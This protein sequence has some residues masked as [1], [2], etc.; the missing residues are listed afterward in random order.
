MNKSRREH[1]V[2]LL[3]AGLLLG[4]V[5]TVGIRYWN[6]P[7]RRTD[8][9]RVTAVFSSYKEIYK[10]GNIQKIVVYFED[11]EQLSIDGICVRHE[12]EKAISQIPPG[13]VVKMMVHPNSDVIL[14]MEYGTNM[15]LDFDESIQRL[16]YEIT[17]FTCLGVFCYIMAA[18][19][20]GDLVF[21]KIHKIRR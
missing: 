20:G 1:A 18:V 11:H 19:G 14:E 3:I 6:A 5:F 21:Q 15:L 2:F 12:Q 9:E 8:T 4:T 16:S 13:T 17:A 10:R 7:V